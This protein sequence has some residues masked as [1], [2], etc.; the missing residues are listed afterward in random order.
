MY[1]NVQRVRDKGALIWIDLRDRYG[2][3]QLFLQDGV[4][5][6]KLIEQA[7]SFG[8]EYVLQAKGTVVERESKNPNMPTGEIEIKVSEFNLL[9]ASKVPPF[10]I[11]DESDGGDD[12]RMKYR[13]LDLRRNPVRR[14]LELRHNMGL[15]FLVL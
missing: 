4:S 14:N 7:R 13:Y 1:G 10:T 8:R 12:L 15:L 5:D 2:I 11:E 9:N 3:T 6:P